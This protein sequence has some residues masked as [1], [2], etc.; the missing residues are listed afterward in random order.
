[1]YFRTFDRSYLDNSLSV[2]NCFR[3][4]KKINTCIRYL[5]KELSS[6]IIR[7]KDIGR[8]KERELFFKKYSCNIFIFINKSLHLYYISL[9]IYMYNSLALKIYCTFHEE[10][11]WIISLQYTVIQGIQTMQ[12]LVTA[13]G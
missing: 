11:N 1:M 2:F 8:W 12:T 9:F 6:K 13:T 3:K 4:A 7:W 10:K 5:N